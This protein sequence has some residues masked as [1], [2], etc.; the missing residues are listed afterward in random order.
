MSNTDK[1]KNDI[2]STDRVIAYRSEDRRLIAE[3]YTVSYKNKQEKACTSDMLRIT[4]M[5]R[6]WSDEAHSYV[7]IPRYVDIPQAAFLEM[8]QVLTGAPLVDAE[9]K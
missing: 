2:E 5:K 3:T 8:I 1:K 4:R 6:Q 9:T 7:D